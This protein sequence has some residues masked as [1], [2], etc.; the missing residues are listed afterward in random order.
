[1]K[2]QFSAGGIIYRKHN[3]KVEIAL[4]L[5]S[6]G[7]WTF[8]KGHIEKGEK[9]EI[10]AKREVGEEIGITNL[11]IISLIDKIDYWFKEKDELIHK[12][13]YYYLIAAPPESRLKAQTSEIKDAQWFLPE[14]AEEK[15]GYKKNTLEVFN[16]AIFKL[17]AI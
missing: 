5:D 12:F 16:K 13:V 6:F 1:V 9:P 11:K 2:F 10:A 15:L 17:K 4:I 3:S 14:E 8:P 7:K